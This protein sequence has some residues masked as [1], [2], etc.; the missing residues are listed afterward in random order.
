MMVLTRF[1]IA[2]N[3]ATLKDEFLLLIYEGSDIVGVGEESRGIY[4]Y[5]RC[6]TSKKLEQ[7]AILVRHS[8]GVFTDAAERKARH[9]GDLSVAPD[10]RLF[11]FDAGVI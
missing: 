10:V 9:I 4:I 1:Y 5:A 7:R 2:K 6:D 8:G 3:N 11:F